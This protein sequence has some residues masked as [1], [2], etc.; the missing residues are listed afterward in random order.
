MIAATAL[1]A[2]VFVGPAIASVSHG[3]LYEVRLPR[4]DSRVVENLVRW[5]KGGNGSCSEET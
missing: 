5:A 4:I 3:P 1:A 2:C